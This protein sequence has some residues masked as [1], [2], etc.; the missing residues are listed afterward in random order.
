MAK[1]N[2]RESKLNHPKS[3]EDYIV[4]DFGLFAELG[5][6]QRFQTATV[7]SQGGP[8]RGFGPLEGQPVEVPVSQTSIER[9]ATLIVGPGGTRLRLWNGITSRLEHAELDV[10]LEE[11]FASPFAVEIEAGLRDALAT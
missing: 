4:V 9:L 5:D 6:G 8:R 2:D 1:L 11:L 7:Y 10:G 3:G